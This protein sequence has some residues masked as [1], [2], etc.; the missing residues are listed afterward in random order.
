MRAFLE[1]QDRGIDPI[2]GKPA[3]PGPVV[4]WV[5]GDRNTWIIELTADFERHFQETGNGYFVL[6]AY[7][8][9]TYLSD[10]AAYS[11]SL[12][13]IDVGLSLIIK[14]LLAGAANP[15]GDPVKR[16]ERSL[17]EQARKRRRDSALALAVLRHLPI[18]RGSETQ[19]V[20]DVAAAEGFGGTVVGDAWRDFKNR[21]RRQH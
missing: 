1:L 7:D 17:L 5:R 15:F 19:A 8:A 12:A 10:R 11:D 4:P 3:G 2:T 9:A 18:V 20:A 21:R 13:W 6:A 16:G 14:R